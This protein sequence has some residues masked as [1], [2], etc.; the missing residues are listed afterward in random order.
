MGRSNS[1]EVRTHTVSG[2]T[3]KGVEYWDQPAGIW[4][5]VLEIQSVLREECVARGT[6]APPSAVRQT[7]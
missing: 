3:F 2:G 4:V 5:P 7:R 6:C 1:Y